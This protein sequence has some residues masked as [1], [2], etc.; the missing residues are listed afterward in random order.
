MPLGVESGGETAGV[1]VGGDDGV[2]GAEDGGD[3]DA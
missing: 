3:D 2:G 1:C